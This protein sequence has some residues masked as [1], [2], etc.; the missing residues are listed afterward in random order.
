MALREGMERGAPAPASLPAA[1]WLAI[2]QG[3]YFIATGAWPIV[4]MRTFEAVTGPKRDRWLVKTVGV[5]V[6]VIGAALVSAGRRG[7]AG[8][9]VRLLGLG[10]AAGLGAIDTI[11]ALRGRISPISLLDAVVEAAL[12]GAWLAVSPSARA[13]AGRPPARSRAGSP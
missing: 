5:L 10:T 8:D 12:A 6:G 13:T 7:R 2:G 9:D 4:S 11:Y 1:A 3:A